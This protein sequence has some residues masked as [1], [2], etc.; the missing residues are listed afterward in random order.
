M[1]FTLLRYFVNRTF[2]LV[3]KMIVHS[4]IR[5]SSPGLKNGI[6]K[7]PTVFFCQ[8]ES[9]Y[10]LTYG[11]QNTTYIITYNS[12]A[13]LFGLKDQRYHLHNCNTIFATPFASSNSKFPDRSAR[14]VEGDSYSRPRQQIKSCCY[15]LMYIYVYILLLIFSF[16][17][18]N[19]II[20]SSQYTLRIQ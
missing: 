4:P 11:L 10:R 12:F 15:N 6:A 17:F 1:S 5:R 3:E 2:S 8:S 18:C 16:S 14:K 13:E 7:L 19:S 20:H 9:Y